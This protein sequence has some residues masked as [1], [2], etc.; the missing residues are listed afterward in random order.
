MALRFRVQ[1]SARSPL[2]DLVTSG[3]FSQVAC[4]GIVSEIAVRA[5]G[6]GHLSYPARGV[7]FHSRE[8]RFLNDSRA[9][10]VDVFEVT[11]A[12]QADVGNA[13][14][15]TLLGTGLIVV[16]K[17]NDLVAF[18]INDSI[19]TIALNYF[20]EF[21]FGIILEYGT[22]SGDNAFFSICAD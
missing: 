10:G 14:E 18:A 21:T 19:V 2:S 13:L 9:A 1:S 16:S 22:V 7:V 4:G 17:P 20:L 5:V 3:N 15:F 6:S 11:V 8:I 12:V